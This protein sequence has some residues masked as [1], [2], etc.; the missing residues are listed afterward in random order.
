M[1]PYFEV[2]LVYA[3][4]LECFTGALSH[5]APA[6]TFGHMK[7][8]SKFFGL[9]FASGGRTFYWPLYNSAHLFCRNM[10][11]FRSATFLRPSEYV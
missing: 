1:L 3:T 10:H 4:S 2:V 9:P 8:L 5:V 6:L 11:P 7:T